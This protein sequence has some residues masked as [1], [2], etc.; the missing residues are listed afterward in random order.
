MPDTRDSISLLI[1]ADNA[2]A[3]RMDFIISIY[4]WPF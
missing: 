1:D 3:A 4:T 2:P